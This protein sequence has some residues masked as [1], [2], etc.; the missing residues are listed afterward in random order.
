MNAADQ[1]FLVIQ[2]AQEEQLFTHRVERVEHLAEL[3][4]LAFPAGPPFFAVESIPGEQAGEPHRQF[5]GSLLRRVVAPYRERLEP[6]KRHRH[7]DTAEERP[8]GNGLTDVFSGPHGYLLRESAWR[9][10]LTPV[11]LSCASGAMYASWR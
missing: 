11:K 7:A 4:V 3:H 9:S 10:R 5:R 8:P 1:G 6:R 2:P